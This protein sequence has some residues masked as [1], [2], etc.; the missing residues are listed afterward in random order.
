MV[1]LIV[2]PVDAEPTSGLTR[3]VSP[4]ALS[5]GVVV[6]STVSEASFGDRRSVYR[7]LPDVHVEYSIEHAEAAARRAAQAFASTA[8]APLGVEATILGRVGDPLGVAAAVATA[9]NV[10]ALYFTDGQSRLRRWYR[11][12]RLTRLGFAGV[13]YHHSPGTTPLLSVDAERMP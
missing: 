9:Y 8:L 5:D 13:V 10:D 11:R 6:L 2:H 1:L 3:L 7:D 12:W 4:H